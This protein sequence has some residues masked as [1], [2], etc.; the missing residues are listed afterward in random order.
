MKRYI[1]SERCTLFFNLYEKLTKPLCHLKLGFSKGL[2]FSF[3][4]SKIHA[5]KLVIQFSFDE[6]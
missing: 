6:P 3:G 2:L 5:K 4:T 1:E